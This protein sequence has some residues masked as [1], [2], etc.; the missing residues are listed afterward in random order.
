MHRLFVAIELPV[1]VRDRLLDVMGGISGAR[2]QRDDQLHLTLR[3]VGEVDRNMAQDIAAALGGVH[4]APF[5]LAVSGTGVFDRRGVTETLW[6]GVTPHDAVTA[7]HLKVDQAL[8]RAGV[9]PDARAYQPHIT[10]ARLGRQSGPVTGFMTTTVLGG[11]AFTVSEFA[12]YESTLTR[13]GA[14]YRIAERYPLR[15]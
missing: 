14:A 9:V 8:R 7:L 11:F 15:P 13:E 10:L 6:A 3:F 4:A 2:W 5:E 12:L 1:A